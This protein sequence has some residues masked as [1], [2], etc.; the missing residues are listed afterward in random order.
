M[1]NSPQW[2]QILQSIGIIG[3]L[4]FTGISFLREGRAKRA[5]NYLDL[6]KA[7]REL[8]TWQLEHPDLA[9][10]ENR[11]VGDA[12]NLK[13]SPIEAQFLRFR[14]FQLSIYHRLLKTG[15]ID[16]IEGVDLDIRDFLSYPLVRNFWEENKIF[17]DSDF[18]QFVEAALS[19]S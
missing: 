1:T 15:Q 10:L 5:A 18:V 8:W 16:P 11:N 2:L 13:L 6:V 19:K 12:N 4:I 3:G 17:Y 9:R 7:H 14:V